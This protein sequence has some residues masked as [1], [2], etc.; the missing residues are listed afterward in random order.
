MAQSTALSEPQSGEDKFRFFFVLTC[1]EQRRSL[2]MMCAALKV[3]TP[4][5][6]VAKLTV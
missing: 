5:M 6:N 1:S 2:L 3:N 4:Q